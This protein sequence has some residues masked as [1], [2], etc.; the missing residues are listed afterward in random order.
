MAVFICWFF[1]AKAIGSVRKRCG[2]NELDYS[3]AGKSSL[4][5][6]ELDYAGLLNNKQ[7]HDV[8]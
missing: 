2:M 8:S 3:N 5:N 6:A 4:P 1:R 7:L